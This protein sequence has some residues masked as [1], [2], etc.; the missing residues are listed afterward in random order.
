MLN[1]NDVQNNNI[2]QDNANQINTNFEHEEIKELD[3]FKWD[4]S[5]E[6]SYNSF[7][8]DFEEDEIVEHN[9]NE[10]EYKI[11]SLFGRWLK[12]KT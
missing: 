4:D 9:N 11:P 6:S 3:N 12:D 7:K 10:N 8:N 2:I 1:D 5:D